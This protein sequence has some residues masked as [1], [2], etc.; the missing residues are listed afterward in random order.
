MQVLFKHVSRHSLTPVFM[1]RKL[2]KS[3]A[4]VSAMTM[5]SRILGFIRDMVIARYFGASVGTDAFFVANKIPNFLRRLFAEGAFSQSFVPVLSEYQTQKDNQAVHELIDSV[6]G[7]LAAYLFLITLIGVVAAPI[8]IMIFAPGF[9][10]EPGK[11]DLATD[12]LRLT[13]PYLFFI[14]LVAFAGGILNSN[15]RF[16]VPSLTPVLLNLSLIGC[17]IWLAPELQRPVMALAWGVFFGGLI[18]LG[19]QLPFLWRLGLLPR[20]RW[21]HTHDGVKRI[22]KLIVP[23]IF[24]SSVA[25]ISLLVDTLLASFLVTGSISWLYF[26][27]RLMEFPLVVFAIAF[28]TVM[29]P[30]LSR[31]HA[32]SDGE[33]FSNTLDWGLRWVFLIGIPAAIGLFVLA[34]PMLSTLFEYEKFDRHS[35]DMARLSLMAYAAGLP[36]FMLIK[37]LAPGYFARQDTKTPVRFGIIAMSSNMVLNLILIFPLQHTGLALATSLSAFLNGALLYHGLRKGEHY[38]P[39]SGWLKLGVRVL[40]AGAVMAVLLLWLAGDQDSWSAMGGWDR[41]LRLSGIILAGAV[42]YLVSLVLLGLRP[43]ALRSQQV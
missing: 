27:D 32:R 41:A 42:A 2:L 19:F 15:G 1:S 8:V 33:A 38:R 35:V 28:A 36:G 40:L 20:P 5:V 29:L 14:S 37:V 24:G 30:K 21:N 12:M 23:A 4:V 6:A 10:D 16:M 26:S 9:I 3:S 7:T 31:E 43:G 13:F 25:Q 39:R 34:G 11:S 22:K 18:Q 17:A